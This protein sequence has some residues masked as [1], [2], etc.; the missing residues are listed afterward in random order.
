MINQLGEVDELVIGGYHASD[1][2]KKVGEMALNNGIYTLVDLDMTDLFFNL[3]K[4]DDY[5]VLDSYEPERF[6]NYMIKR[7]KRYGE[8]LAE[9]MF[10][11]NYESDVYGFS[12]LS[13]NQNK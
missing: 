2:V 11:R 6:K 4:K 13:K 12:E 5:F 10:I 9:R 3:Y 1:C 7:M 8:D